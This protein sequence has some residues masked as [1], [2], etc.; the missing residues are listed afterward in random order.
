MRRQI[1]VIEGREQSAIKVVVAV[2]P[3]WAAEAVAPQDIVEDVV[4]GIW[5]EHRAEPAVSVAISA[6]EIVVGDGSMGEMARARNAGRPGELALV[7]A[8]INARKVPAAEI[9]TMPSRLRV[10][11]GCADQ[12]RCNDE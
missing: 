6:A 12:C 3:E 8:A 5:P 11:R 4:V 7:D 10:H 2:V 1:L 9:N